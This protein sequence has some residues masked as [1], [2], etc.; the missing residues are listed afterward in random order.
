MRKSHCYRF[1]KCSISLIQFDQLLLHRRTIYFSLRDGIMDVW[2]ICNVDFLSTLYE[3]WDKIAI[4]CT[5]LFL[6]FLNDYRAR[7]RL[8]LFDAI[9]LSDFS[10]LQLSE[11][12]R[13][14]SVYVVLVE[15]AMLKYSRI[16]ICKRF[17]AP[18]R[19][20]RRDD[21]IARRN[22]YIHTTFMLLAT[23]PYICTSNTSFSH[24]TVDFA[25]V[26]QLRTVQSS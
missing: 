14:L 5:S 10:L 8:K 20:L 19:P 25:A 7:A 21:F 2:S 23:W 13:L 3:C 24:S 22:S 1:G 15:L 4:V 18:S 26:M 9:P 12:V 6:F 16:G 17:I 11:I